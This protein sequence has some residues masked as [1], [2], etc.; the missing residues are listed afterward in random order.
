M[1]LA[2]QTVETVYPESDGKPMGETDVHRAW[3]IRI[4]D[5]MAQRYRGQRVYV[6]SDLLLYYEEGLP[7][8]YVVPDDFIVLDCEPGDRRTFQTWK[9]GRIPNVVFE[10]TSKWTR[11]DDEVFKI[12]LYADLGVRE[13]FL[14][15]PTA[16]YL[17]PPLKGY[18]LADDG[19]YAPLEA[20]TQGSIESAELGIRLRLQGRKLVMTDALTGNRL[21]TE[22]ET[23][24][25]AGQ[26][27]REARERE[28]AAREAAEQ[29]AVAAEAE[30]ARLRAEMER[31]RG[32]N[33]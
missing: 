3:M 1:S 27:E 4:Y 30:V 22:A 17:R 10:V 20:D 24:R 29:R 15:D 6:A 19:A 21:L 26:R 16:D 23:E 5:L 2:Q 12:K 18:R 25:Q 13:L 11:R 9:E 7:S 32:S 33:D 8:K 28:R 14:Y 31:L